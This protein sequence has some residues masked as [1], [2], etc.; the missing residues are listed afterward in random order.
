MI[1]LRP[2]EPLDR[3]L[4]FCRHLH[5]SAAVG[6]ARDRRTTGVGDLEDNHR[7]DLLDRD[8]RRRGA[9][10]LD[11]CLDDRRDETYPS[12]RQSDVRN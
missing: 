10:L 4:E 8:L 2:N 12:S 1:P 11:P 5:G 3:H 7:V 9:A 6:D